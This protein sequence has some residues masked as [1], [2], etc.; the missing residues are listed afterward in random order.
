MNANNHKPKIVHR[1]TLLAAAI[2][3]AL[4]SAT[5]LNGVFA[6]PEASLDARNENALVQTSS[7]ANLI[8]SVKPAVVNISIAGKQ[9][10]GT[11]L[12]TPNFEFPP[13]SPFEDLFRHFFDG[14][15]EQRPDFG[16]TP[17]TRAMGSGF[18]ID[19][20][21]YVVTNHHVIDAGNTI[22]VKLNDG[23]QYAAEV[24]GAD[25]KT[26]LALLKIDADKPLPFVSFGESDLAR[27]GDWVVAIGNPFGLGGTA[28]T[29]IISAR[30]RDI[31]SGPF[32]DY[33]QI[34]APINRG[35]SGGPL[36]DTSG[37]VVGVN[38]AIY[39][40][41]GGSVGIGFA[42]PSAMV[43]SVIEQLRAEGRVERG[44]LGVTIQP[45]DDDVANSLA[46][47]KP[48]GALV[49]GVTTDSPAAKAGLRPG[50]VILSFNGKE[51]EQ[52]KDLPWLVADVKAGKKVKMEV[53][54]DGKERTLKA[55][56][57]STPEQDARRAS[58]NNP[59]KLSAGK[60]GLKLA[61]IS[62]DLRQRYRIPSDTKGVLILEVAP[63]SPANAKGLRAGDVISMVG[64]TRVD[65]P[66][67]VVREV[68]KASSKSKTI[69]LLVQRE[70]RGQFVALNIA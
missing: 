17:Q 37:R 16:G 60:L 11:S 47:V 65:N 31:Q 69:L 21:G 6:V 66:E 19:A 40:P 63:N 35:N 58:A 46:M 54:R 38:T 44:W 18:I 7:F 39:S 32:D 48:Q 3:A 10:A 2:S 24:V 4:I 13:G 53:W 50:D 64:Q 45:V 33:I 1:R 26:D 68:K 57:Q 9:T 8:Q 43:K 42:I 61:A 20:S 22:T 51:V 12:A 27:V 30:G 5:A 70:D 59:D 29:G 41:N 14:S 52:M 25:P 67:D 56:I 49:A 62:P 15:P 23:S 36:F 28:T 34:D 55:I